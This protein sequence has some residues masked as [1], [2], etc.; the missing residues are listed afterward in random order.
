MDLVVIHVIQ[1]ILLRPLE[2]DLVL[3]VGEEV[4]SVMDGCVQIAVNCVRT[5]TYLYVSI[6]NIWC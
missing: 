6:I 2:A 1:P 4:T 3:R 5:S